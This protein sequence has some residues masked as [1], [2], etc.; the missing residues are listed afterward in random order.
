M[1]CSRTFTRSRN[2]G[3]DIVDV[4]S[5][6][7]LNNIATADRIC[8]FLL[9]VIILFHRALNATVRLFYLLHLPYRNQKTARRHT[10]SCSYLARP[11]TS[12]SLPTDGGSQFKC[13]D[14][15]KVYRSAIALTNHAK[16]HLGLTVC[17]ICSK[18]YSIIPSLRIHL[19]A[20]HGLA[21][22]EVYRLIP[23]RRIGRR[24]LTDPVGAGTPATRASAV[25]GPAAAGPGVATVAA[26]AGP[27]V[28]STVEETTTSGA[29]A[30]VAGS[31]TESLPGGAISSIEAAS[32][33]DSVAREDVSGA[34]RT[35]EGGVLTGAESYGYAAV[36]G[37]LSP[38][39]D[40]MNM[41]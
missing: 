39:N 30:G 16:Q 3:K 13:G 28:A 22:A 23:Q 38:N 4:L 6:A 7:K 9:V 10:R 36:E 26:A 2:E 15:D 41:P 20:V 11:I 17:P 5:Y 25:H 18:A 34:M 12:L 19:R 8:F 35:S 33:T 14:C 31:S 1:N 27:G 40:S 32:P 21:A 37:E 29:T 24:Y